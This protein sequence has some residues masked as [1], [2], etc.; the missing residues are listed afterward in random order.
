MRCHACFLR[1]SSKK[2]RYRSFYKTFFGEEITNK[3]SFIKNKE[4][5]NRRLCPSYKDFYPINAA[6]IE[7][8]ASCSA[9]TIE[10][11]GYFL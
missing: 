9:S 6:L 7:G 8:N 10:T 4:R 2:Q 5:P 3:A 11:F 1:L